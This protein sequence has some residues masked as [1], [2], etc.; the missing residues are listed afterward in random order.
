MRVV[1][2]DLFR[3]GRSSSVQ[4]NKTNHLIP[5]EKS[6]K[7]GNQR[8]TSV[9]MTMDQQSIK[10]NNNQY[11]VGFVR[12]N[13]VKREESS[14]GK[15]FTNFFK[16]V[17]IKSFIFSALKQAGLAFLHV[18]NISMGIHVK[19]KQF[20]IRMTGEAKPIFYFESSVEF[21]IVKN[22]VFGVGITADNTALGKLTQ[23]LFNKTINLFGKL[24]EPRVSMT[25]FIILLLLLLIFIFSFIDAAES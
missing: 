24:R 10:R 20:A 13:K 3:R 7:H 15:S 12:S 22:G 5:N 21:E 23:A 6:N 1:F 16:T 9:A 2:T 25:Y 19:D 4:Q 14:M 11:P 17:D 8:N 18:Y